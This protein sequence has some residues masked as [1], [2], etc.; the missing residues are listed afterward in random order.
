MAGSYSLSWKS[1]KGSAWRRGS[2]A[3]T[4]AVLCSFS[5][6]A[7]SRIMGE[8]SSKA[9]SRFLTW[10]GWA[11]KPISSEGWS[12]PNCPNESGKPNPGAG[13]NC[14]SSAEGVG[15]QKSRPGS[16]WLGAKRVGKPRSEL[17]WSCSKCGKEA[18]EPKSRVGSTFWMW[19]CWDGEPILKSRLN[20]WLWGEGAGEPNS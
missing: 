18:G 20:C 7:F 11:S 5:I 17:G 16:S 9:E 2:N 6:P 15:E 10:A 12:C 14:R 19:A 4:W 8:P 13:L 1:C 3:W